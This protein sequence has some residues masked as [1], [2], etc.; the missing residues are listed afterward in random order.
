MSR[1]VW[2]AAGPTPEGLGGWKHPE[3]AA[4][5]AVKTILWTK[6]QIQVRKRQDQYNPSRMWCSIT[7]GHNRSN[8]SVKLPPIGFGRTSFLLFAIRFAM[9][10]KYS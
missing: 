4:A 3:P 10:V 2:G 8:V 1:G 7:G 9:C 5:P 6:N